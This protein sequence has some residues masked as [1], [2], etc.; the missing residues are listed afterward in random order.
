MVMT[1]HA[2]G[3]PRSQDVDTAIL[4][5]AVELLAVRGPDGLTINAVARRSGVARASIYLRF[6]GR[7]ALLAA[8]IRAAIGR[9]PFALSGDLKTDIRLSAGQAQAILANPGFRAALPEIVRGL[10]RQAEGGADAIS[11][12]TVAPNRRP[13]AEEYR[14]QA[15][16][17]GLRTDVDPDLVGCMLVGSLLMLL[18]ASGVPPTPGMAAQTAEIIL[19]GLKVPAAA[20][21]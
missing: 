18:L 17:S 3:R 13:I 7:D 11:Y 5:A 15:A 9:E 2:P 12:D 14:H 10:L 19:E 20:A 8:T 6:P 16:N 21:V 1:S 4:Q